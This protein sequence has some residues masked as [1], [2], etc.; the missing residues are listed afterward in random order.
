MARCQ[1]PLGPPAALSGSDMGAGHCGLRPVFRGGVCLSAAQGAAL[2][3]SVLIHVVALR[4]LSAADYALLGLVLVVGAGLQSVLAGG[5][6]NALR[7]AAGACSNPAAVW[8]APAMSLH[9]A[10]CGGVWLGLLWLAHEVDRWTGSADAWPVMAAAATELFVRAGLLD[11]SVFILNGQ[12]RYR[13]QAALQIGFQAGRVTLFV[14]LLAHGWGSAGAMTGLAV[15]AFT[16]GCAGL[17]LVRPWRGRA[18]VES[19]SLTA[20]ADL[21]AWLRYGGSHDGLLFM[22]PVANLCLVKGLVAGAAEVAVYVACFVAARAT[23]SLGIVLAGIFFA[24]AARAVSR[25]DAN[26]VRSFL[27]VGVRVQVLLLAPLVALGPFRGPE[28]LQKAC[29]FAGPP[30]GVLLATL[31]AAGALLTIWAFV[32]EMLAAAG[33]LRAR[34][35]L[36]AGAAA[37]G[38]AGMWAATYAGGLQGAAVGLLATAA[39]GAAG[40]IM[41]ADRALGPFVPWRG[42]GRAVAAVAVA[43]MVG[44][45]TAFPPGLAWGA[46]DAAVC[47]GIYLGLLVLSGTTA[48]RRL[49]ET[50]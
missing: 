26:S 11:P 23:A 32:G 30:S 21:A 13:A 47:G 7:R 25:N 43:A 10:V 35:R 44:S 49:G 20:E 19:R 37:G 16:A 41:L 28:F 31:L 14:I 5:I 15:A 4:R 39:V 12:A 46:V 29:G 24:P 36:A 8:L 42:V 22:I 2:A 1:D 9:V 18:D 48:K 38:L 33:H 17:W 50:R 27:A 40:S 3:G 6:P 45:A 34:L